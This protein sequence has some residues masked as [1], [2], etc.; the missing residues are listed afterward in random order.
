MVDHH[1]KS[2]FIWQIEHAC[3]GHVLFFNPNHV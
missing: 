3:N 1:R 2:I